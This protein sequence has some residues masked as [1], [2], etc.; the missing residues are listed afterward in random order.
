MRGCAPIASPVYQLYL[1]FEH[2]GFLQADSDNK[3][4]AN[5]KCHSQFTDTVD[6]RRPGRNTWQDESGVYANSMFKLS[7]AVSKL[8]QPLI[9][10]DDQ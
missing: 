8:S 10:S 3:T 4:I 1:Q 5:K 9:L 6:Y 7:D 2:Y